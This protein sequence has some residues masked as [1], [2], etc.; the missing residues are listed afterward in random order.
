MFARNVN[1]ASVPITPALRAEIRELRSARHQNVV[2]FI[3]ACVDGPH[4]CVV[5]EFA[6]KGSLDDI[7]A[8][9][10]INLD[11]EFRYSILKDVSSG[12]AYLHN[13]PIGVHGRLKSSNCVVD[14]RWT[15]KVGK[16]GRVL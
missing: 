9:V 2:S 15:V 6:A 1:K 8:N 16:G 3:G 14:S 7:L 5:N 11:W 4:T 10:D 12:M 13:S